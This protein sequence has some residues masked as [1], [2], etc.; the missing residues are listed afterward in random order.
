[1]NVKAMNDLIGLLERRLGKSW[2]DIVDW[3]ISQNSLGAIERALAAGNLENVVAGVEAAAAKFAAET[4]NTYITAGRKMSE[5]LD[6]KVSTR[7]IRFDEVNHVAVARAEANR[8]ELVSGLAEEQRSTLRGI[9]SNGAKEGTNPLEL[10]KEIRGSIGLTPHQSDAVTSYRR[11]LE[12]GDYGNALGR[13]LRDARS[14]RT[15]LAAQRDRKALAPDRIDAMTDKYRENFVT[16]RAETIA[17]TEALRSANEG[18]DDAIAQAIERG[19]VD[20]DELIKTWSSGPRTRYARPD[21][22]KMDDVHVPWKEDFTLPDGSKMKHP[23]DPRGGPEN[24]INCRCVASTTFA[25][26][27]DHREPA[28]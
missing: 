2:I 21:H 24:T 27:A 20:R 9:I 18:A 26:Q 15:L 8:L 13:E 25:R 28:P 19:D 4:H 22:Q 11:A 23:G 16:H 6:G 12:N 14:D 10:A 5:W 3:L 7:L 1:M 17:R